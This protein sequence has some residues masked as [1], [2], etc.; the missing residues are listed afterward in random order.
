MSALH[1][2][3]GLSEMTNHEFLDESYR[4]Q[5]TTFADGTQ[6]TIDLDSDT[7]EITPKLPEPTK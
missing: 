5:R 1:E 6:V 7:F 4:K 2:R 3:V